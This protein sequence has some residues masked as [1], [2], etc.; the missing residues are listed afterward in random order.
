MWQ[1][2]DE[3][4]NEIQTRLSLSED[5]AEIEVRKHLRSGDI[6]ARGLL[7]NPAPTTVF[8]KITV[9]PEGVSPLSVAAG[10]EFTVEI[11]PRAFETTVVDF[12]TSQIIGEG[13]EVVRLELDMA[14]V[15][16][17]VDGSRNA[18]KIR[19]RLMTDELLEYAS[20]HG[21]QS[22]QQL[23]RHLQDIGEGVVEAMVPIPCLPKSSA[24]LNEIVNEVLAHCPELGR[25]KTEKS[26]I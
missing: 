18:T 19:L 12:E 23:V 24:R 25:R 4:M 5:D 3:T 6:R 16:Q 15:D 14:T 7:R 17:M 20:G 2:L 8:E 1:K 13:F 21:F 26:E 11:D 9:G 22:K 10:P